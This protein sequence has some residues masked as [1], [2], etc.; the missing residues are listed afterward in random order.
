M[1]TELFNTTTDQPVAIDDELSNSAVEQLRHI[2]HLHETLAQNFPEVVIGT[3]NKEMQFGPIGAKRVSMTEI[4]DLGSGHNNSIGYNI[5]HLEG[6]TLPILRRAFHGESVVYEARGGDRYFNIKAIPLKEANGA[7]N[8]VLCVFQDITE[9]KKMQEGLIAA[10]DREKELGEL[11]SRFVTMASHEFRTPLTAILA[12]TFLLESYSGDDYSKEKIVHTS[13]IKR[14]VNNLTNILNEFLSLEKLEANKVSVFHSDINIPEYFQDDLIG[15]MDLIKKAGQ[16]IEYDHKGKA[17]VHLDH[18]LLWS[19][20]TNLISNALKYSR[21][22]SIIRVNSDLNEDRLLITVEDRGIG[23]PADEHK[24]IFGRFF[25]ARN[26]TNI[27]G[28]GLG[29][30][31]TQ[32]YVTLLNGEITFDSRLDEGTKFTVTLPTGKRP[33]TTEARLTET[34]K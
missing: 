11:K 32:K 15:E 5:P 10:L 25:R 31:I 24:N 19:I 30:H 20:L 18:H 16:Q 17:I 26:A 23:I 12:S 3:L 27:E 8:E 14:S 9:Q 1:S 6:D 21:I 33:A 13:R 7:I 4:T 22:E 2:R 34:F 29:L 28:T